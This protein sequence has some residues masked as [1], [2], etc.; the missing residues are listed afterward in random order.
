MISEQDHIYTS[1]KDIQISRYLVVDAE[2]G[3]TPCL[4]LLVQELV[5]V[6]E[7]GLLGTVQVIPP[8]TR[9]VRLVVVSRYQLY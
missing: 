3:L 4:W 2:E 7:G 9:N 5:Q 8:E 6:G 1:N